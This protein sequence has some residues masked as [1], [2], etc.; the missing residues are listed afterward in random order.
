MKLLQLSWL[1][2][3]LLIVSC[4]SQQPQ[5]LSDKIETI[6]VGYVNWACDCANF[7]ETRYYKASN[8]YEVKEED[9]IY[10]EPSDT[11]IKI[12]DSYFDKGHFEKHLILT[13]RFY[14]DKGVPSTY[15]NKTPETPETAKVFRYTKFEFVKKISN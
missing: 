8:N 13:G 2:S 12:P 7:I 5:K 1:C 6:E 3:F 11:S 10:I 15:D 4:S 14:I 9:C